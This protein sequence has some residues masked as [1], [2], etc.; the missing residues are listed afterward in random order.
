VCKGF[1]EEKRF[2]LAKKK[3]KTISYF[4]QILNKR[5]AI[6]ILLS[7]VFIIGLPL[8]IQN[9]R[10]N[11]FISDDAWWHY[12]QINQVIEYSHRLNP[13]TYEFVTLNRPMTYPPLFHYLV[14]LIYKFL[15]RNLSLIKFCHYFNIIE[16]ML[17]IL[18][19]YGISYVIT[20]DRLFSI[21]GALTASVSYGIIIR[22]RAGELMPFVLGDLLSLGGVLLLLILLKDIPNN[23]I[24]LSLT[25]GILFGLSLLSWSGGVLIYLPLILFIFLSFAISRPKLSKMSLNLFL[26]CFIPAILIALPWYLPLILK[27]GIY[28]HTKEMEW[29]MKGFTVLHQVRPLSFYI[30]TSGISIFFIPI[31]LIGALFRRDALNIFFI[32][33]IILG[34]VA[35]Y[36]GWRGYVAV[37]PI[38]STIAISIGT[39]RIIGFLFKGDSRF[40]PLVFI[41]VFLLVGGI[42]YY[43]SNLRLKPLDPKNINEVRTNEK[44][45]RMLE[46][47]K[48][49]YP[50]A[51]TID[52]ISWMSES[53]A[54]GDLR[55]VGG[56][57]L[58]YLPPGSSEV[59]KDISRFYLTD[60]EGAFDICQKYNTDLIIVRKQ[61][62]QP[63]QLSLLFAPPELKSEDY[64]KITKESPE[65]S[66]MTIT[67]TPK[68]IQTMLFKMICRQKL[69]NFELVYADQEKN[70]PF[71]F[72]V[73]YKVKK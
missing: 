56:Q 7:F 29:F 73:V 72:V 9:I 16:G 37:V 28:P 13:D 4:N 34:I 39:S 49:K 68:G 24:L 17:Y 35:T 41:I 48:D 64:L 40:I 52:H 12:R 23:S 11:G 26:F 30:L 38:I 2:K 61:L 6:I 10:L 36:T 46:F 47:L 59:L 70:E 44:S 31:A 67:F 32:S 42:G 53:E 65:S 18:I 27:Y 66:E 54:V 63:A 60:E 20:N 45:I 50:K 19:I 71:P 62:L 43:I 58:E 3:Q 69:K 55:M 33:W 15:G 57:Y 14:S 25:S 22:A 51:V 8:R 5:S 21:I 1:I